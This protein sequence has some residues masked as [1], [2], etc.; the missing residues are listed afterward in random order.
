MGL[1][2]FAKAPKALK[3]KEIKVDKTGP[4]YV[5]IDASGNGFF[6]CYKSSFDVYTDHIE[7]IQGSSSEYTKTNVPLSSLSVVTGGSAKSILPL[8]LSSVMF[9]AGGVLGGAYES[10]AVAFG[11]WL[12][13]AVFFI[14]YVCSKRLV[15]KVVASSG[16]EVAIHLKVPRVNKEDVDTIV[17]TITQLAIAQTA[18]N[19]HA[20][21]KTI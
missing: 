18:R 17:K 21:G 3:L 2:L 12:V 13:A 5:H 14:F 7:Y 19:D 6:L 20:S 15:I 10:A 11:L 16:Q 9:C 1:S 4:Q 8:I